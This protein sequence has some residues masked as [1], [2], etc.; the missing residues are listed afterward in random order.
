MII[1]YMKLDIQYEDIESKLNCHS[2]TERQ[3]HAYKGP[4]N[5]MHIF[6][7]CC[8]KAIVLILYGNLEH[9]AHYAGKWVFSE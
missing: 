5:S 9:V 2:L 6:I 1:H 8:C 7:G 4:C 3:R